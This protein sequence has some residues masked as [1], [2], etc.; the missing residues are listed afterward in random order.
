[1]N[2]N[3]NLT[4]FTDSYFASFG[5]D[6]LV[7]SEYTDGAYYFNNNHDFFSYEDI[8]IRTASGGGGTLLTKGVDYLCI[9]EITDLTT[10]VTAALGVAKTI[11]NKIQILNAAYQ[12]VPIWMSGKWAGDD[13]DVSDLNPLADLRVDAGFNSLRNINF[14]IES[15]NAVTTGTDNIAIGYQALKANM[16]G[17]WNI[18]I[19]SNSLPVN[20]SGLENIAIGY[21]SLL[22]SLTSIRQIAI[23]INALR[24]SIKGGYE[25]AIGY[26]ALYN[27]NCTTDSGNIAVGKSALGGNTTGRNNT[28]IGQNALSSCGIGTQNTALGYFAGN[29]TTTGV[30]VTCIGSDATASTVS[31]SNQITLG[32]SSVTSLRCAVT[33]ITAIS[34]MRDKKEI[35]PL[36]LGAEFIKKLKPIQYKK[37]YRNWYEDKKSDGS[38]MEEAISIGFLAQDLDALDELIDMQIVLKDNPDQLETCEGKLFP[39]IVNA[40]KEIIDRLEKL[41][42]VKA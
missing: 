13:L 19:G 15:L 6:A 10:R 8:V 28:A 11:Y 34:D 3:L 4:S 24:S 1:M 42:G 23:G 5:E 37:D 25:I 29:T 31:A 27:N 9:D 39:V 17:F 16:T 7:L 20:T 14:G 33:T 21:N 38:K 40:L 18:A 2:L 12:A 35:S 41:E 36:A 32:N 26:Q 30:N 22:S